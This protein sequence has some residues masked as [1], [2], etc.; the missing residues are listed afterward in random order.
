MT[1]ILNEAT[2]TRPGNDCIIEA[3]VVLL[4][5]SSSNYAVISTEQALGSWTD[6]TINT[7]KLVIKASTALNL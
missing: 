4:M 3:T 1:K 6:N 7:W 2:S 5:F